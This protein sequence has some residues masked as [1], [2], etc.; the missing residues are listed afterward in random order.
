MAID[1]FDA[2]QVTVRVAS[3]EMGHRFFGGKVS[4][5]EKKLSIPVSPEAYKTGSASLWTGRK[6]TLIKR[7]GK[8]ALLVDANNPE[9]W[10]I[11]YV[12]MSSVVH[13]PDSRAFPPRV[14]VEAAARSMIVE[15]IGL[16]MRSR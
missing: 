11:H 12:L 3:V 14:K 6:L 4:Q 1:S 10:T 7:P 13:R 2:N 8:P 15:K 9:A 16:I 5:G